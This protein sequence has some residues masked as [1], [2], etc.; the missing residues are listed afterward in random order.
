M[1]LKVL[2]AN[3]VRYPLWVAVYL[4]R[5]PFSIA[6]GLPLLLASDVHGTPAAAHSLPARY[7]LLLRMACLALLSAV[8]AV[9]LPALHS[10]ALVT[11]TGAPCLLFR[12][13]SC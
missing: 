1:R 2:L 4:H 8:A 6:L 7:M 5:I 12:A 11:V 13:S 3:Q 9:L 10:V